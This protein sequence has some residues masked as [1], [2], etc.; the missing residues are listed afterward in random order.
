MLYAAYGS[1]L[2]PLRLERRTP[3]ATLLGTARIDGWALTFDKR[4]QDGSGKCTIR[5]GGD[6][7]YC[8]VYDVSRADK[9][10]LDRIEGIGKGYVRAVLEVPGFGDCATYFAEHGCRD[11]TLL[12]FSWYRDLV[13]NGAKALGFDAAYVARIG[14]VTARTDPDSRRHERNALL[15]DAIASARTLPGPV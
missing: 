3:S 11:K 8:A 10:K 5:E 1:N 14:A 9:R 6:G 13:L 15:V 4:G 2:H 12:P 7:I